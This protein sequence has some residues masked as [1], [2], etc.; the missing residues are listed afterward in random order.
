MSNPGENSES[1]DSSSL[2][3]SIE[4]VS[5]IEVSLNYRSHLYIRLL[6]S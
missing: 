4:T 5:R 6:W 1:T 2:D 3:Y